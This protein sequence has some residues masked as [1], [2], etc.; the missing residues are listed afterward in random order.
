M[1]SSRRGCREPRSSY[2]Q[3]LGQIVALDERRAR[4][5]DDIHLNKEPRADMIRPTRVDMQ[6][7]LWMVRQGCPEEA[8]LACATRMVR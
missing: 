8:T 5:H 2:L 4:R 6:Y 3:V 1:V 7:L